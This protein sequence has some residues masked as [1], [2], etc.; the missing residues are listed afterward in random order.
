[1]ATLLLVVARGAIR[2]KPRP[3][4]CFYRTLAA[5]VTTIGAV[6]ATAR[7][8]AYG[9]GVESDVGEVVVVVDVD[10]HSGG[11]V[12]VVGVD[13]LGVQSDGAVVVVVVVVVVVD[14]LVVV[15]GG[16]PVVVV[17]VGGRVV[18]GVVVDVVVVEGRR[19]AGG[20][21]VVAPV[22]AVDDE[23]ALDEGP[24]AD[25]VV[26]DGAAVDVA[27]LPKK[28]ST[29]ERATSSEP[30]PRSQ[31]TPAGSVPPLHHFSALTKSPQRSV[32]SRTL[33]R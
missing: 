20:R 10:V 6:A 24:D 8:P 12:V 5:C 9:G 18:D 4:G 16:G 26:A 1:M 11:A 17:V 3:P 32:S 30:R 33:G 28:G 23:P 15:V 25:D 29:V 31:L 19:V 2:R 22:P 21:V 13:L 27:A 7:W 14:V